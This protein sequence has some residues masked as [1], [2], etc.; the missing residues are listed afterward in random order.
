MLLVHGGRCRH[1]AEILRFAQ[2]D[3][4]G[5]DARGYIGLLRKR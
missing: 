5:G 4:V 2:D 3:S 1:N